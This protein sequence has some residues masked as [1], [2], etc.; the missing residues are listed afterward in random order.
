[1]KTKTLFI[2]ISLISSLLLSC[3]E[4]FPDNIEGETELWVRA[5][6]NEFALLEAGREDYELTTDV[7]VDELDVRNFRATFGRFGCTDCPETFSITLRDYDILANEP[8]NSDSTF[9]LGTRRYRSQFQE[10]DDPENPFT[11]RFKGTSDGTPP[12]KYRW[13]FG[14]GHISTAAQPKHTYAISGDFEARLRI[15]DANGCADNSSHKISVGEHFAECPFDF[16]FRRLGNQRMEFTALRKNGMPITGDVG[17]FWDMGAGPATTVFAQTPTVEMPF[18]IDGIYRV[19][20]LVLDSCACPCP[21]TK[22]IYTA[23]A[24]S[25]VSEFSFKA[26]E[27]DRGLSSVTIE[28]ID[29]SGQRYSSMKPAG[30]Q[31]SSSRFFI[32][33]KEAYKNNQA[34]KPTIR[35]EATFDCFLYNEQNPQ[36]SIMLRGGRSSFAMEL[37]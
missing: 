17:F 22:N 5:D 31:P 23:N 6:W 7:S 32:A 29:P 14:D 24:P 16:T 20:L 34:G 15:E 25:C 21:V 13:D 11:F 33:E 4:Q 8:A 35:M 30:G 10:P 3:G 19:T 37:P 9:L 28:W 18:P 27:P 12:F 2:Y 1:M 36:D 26:L